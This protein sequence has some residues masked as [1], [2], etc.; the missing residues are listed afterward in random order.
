MQNQRT[1]KL[2][3]PVQ[4]RTVPRRSLSDL[5]E[6]RRP[7][8]T[9]TARRERMRQVRHGVRRL[10]G[11]A[12]RRYLAELRRPEEPFLRNA[13]IPAR[14]ASRMPLDFARTAYTNPR[15]LWPF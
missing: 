9:A 2:R 3:H 14:T 13:G 8:S 10:G 6:L 12:G 11:R 4:H 5:A 15:T 7:A 1:I